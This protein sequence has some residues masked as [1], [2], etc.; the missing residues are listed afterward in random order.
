MVKGT[1]LGKDLLIKYE[2]TKSLN[3]FKIQLCYTAILKI[4]NM[5]LK[6]LVLLLFTGSIM[7]A[8]IMETF[9]A[10][11][12]PAGWSTNITSGTDDWRFDLNGDMPTGTDFSSNAAIFDASINDE[13]GLNESQLLS[14]VIDTTPLTN[15]IELS[16]EYSLQDFAGDGDLIVDV[17]DGTTWQ[18]V[19]SISTD[20]NPTVFPFTDMTAFSNAAFQI[21]F[22]YDDDGAA[23]SIWGAGVDNVILRELPSCLEID[24]IVISNITDSSAD[25]AFNDPNSTP[26]ANGYEY[27]VQPVTDPAPTG[28]GT[29]VATTSF[30]VSSLVGITDYAVYIRA[31]CSSTDFSLYSSGTF[32]TSCPTFT[33]PYKQ[34]FTVFPTSL[35]WEEAQGALA[36]NTTL[37]GTTA[38]WLAD[39]LSNDR[40]T[41]AARETISGTVNDEWLISPTISLAGS[42]V[43]RFDLAL[44]DSANPIPITADPNGSTG[45]DDRFIVIISTDNGVTWSDSNI[46]REWNNTGSADV[47]NDIPYNGD[48]YSIDLSAFT[49]DIKIAFYAESTVTNASNDLSIDNFVVESASLC[50]TPSELAVSAFS[51][52]ATDVSIDISWTENGSAT[53]YRYVVVP[54]GDPAPAAGAGTAVTGVSTG[55]TTIDNLLEGTEYDVYLRAECSATDNSLY[56]G[57]FT[58]LTPCTTTTP[59]ILETFDTFSTTN[60]VCWIEASGGLD[61]DRPLS[62]G[63]GSWLQDGF[64]NNGTSGAVAI[65]MSATTDRDWVITAPYDLSAGG[66]ELV[67]D[68]AVSDSGNSN[69]IENGMGT[70]DE[71]KLLASTDG[72]NWTTLQTWAN[73]SE[74]AAGGETVT[75]DL[76]SFTSATAFAFY[77]NEGNIDDTTTNPD[78]QFFFDNFQVRTPPSCGDVTNIAVSNTGS[79]DVE[80]TFDTVMG[81]TQYD[82]EIFAA[83]DDPATATAVATGNVSAS[84]GTA[85]GLAA[86]TAYDLYIASNC[87]GSLGLQQG[88]I[89]FSTLCDAAVAPYLEN[90][91]NFTVSSSE[92]NSQEC[93]NAT[94]QSAFFW[95]VAATTDTS[96]GGTG[97]AANIS[98]GNYIFTEATSGATGDIATASLPLVDVSTLTAP[99]LLFDYHM[100]GVNM[101][102]LEVEIT[103]GG[104]SAIVWSLSG[105]QQ[106]AET[107]PFETAFIDLAAYAGQTIQITFLGTKGASFESDMAIDTVRVEEAPACIPPVFTT[108]IVEDCANNQFSVQVDITSIG[109]ATTVVASDDMMNS[110]TGL[111]TGMVTFGPYNNGDTINFT[112]TSEQDA[113]CTTSLVASFTCPPA[114]DECDDAITITVNADNT[115][116]L[117]TPGSTVAATASTQVDD[118]TGTPDN[119]VWFIFTATATNNIVEITNKTAIVGTSTDMGMGVY[120]A[121]GGCTALVLVDD[122]DPD[123]LQLTGLTVGNDYYVR[124]YGWSATNTAQVTFD[125]CVRTPPPPPVNDDC[126]GAIPPPFTFSQPGG[127]TDADITVDLTTA[128]DA[129]FF[130][131]CDAFGNYDVWYS[132]TAIS[133]EL[134]FDAGAGAPG[135]AVFEG[136]CGNLTEIGC[137]NNLDGTIT[138]LTLGNDYFLVVWDDTA[139]TSVSFGIELAGT[140]SNES[141]ELPNITMYPNPTTGIFQVNGADI[142]RMVIR[143]TLGQTIKTVEAASADLSD[144]ANGL[145][146]IEIYSGDKRSVRRII[147]E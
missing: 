35:C 9:D 38:G 40:T 58:F 44:T 74:P 47:Y 50:P 29:P 92:W 93:W 22:T 81:A 36:A 79:N 65:L 20:V 101:G 82:Y 99:F 129:T 28:A 56:A 57:P 122:S 112:V 96:S 145:Y 133:T 76:S 60:P 142:D 135:I 104:T 103:A 130:P 125:M 68:V 33:A 87:N 89:A 64:I 48:N 75:I 4:V 88:P 131:S 39:G 108:T 52:N 61:S 62:F 98:D 132:F 140:L 115:C 127:S 116:T 86:D 102:T 26:A 8:Q 119:D 124:V 3:P 139:G 41:G 111:G 67:V 63:T 15:G 117:T 5:K 85:T 120:D 11:T 53:D 83:G 137:L 23:G 49:G 37:T 2:A 7:S 128:A 70:D 31:L 13:V 143:N 144:V 110:Q 59:D 113:T 97:P 54:A 27:V 121:A 72:I 146:I 100:H 66:Y 12:I 43:M 6:S 105:E 46:L 147:K 78:Y 94:A 55:T 10:T 95:E 45:S 123:L 77:A 106:A 25:I 32:T 107:D 114:N 21:R 69:V 141:E 84:P 118:V 42:E 24:N 73:G 51:P 90:F 17:F 14:P 34:D 19:F 1:F 138:G 18:N 136:T 109:T 16:F 91:D 126:A 134:A 71:I 80:F 30:S